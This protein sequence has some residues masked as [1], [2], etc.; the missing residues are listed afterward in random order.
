MTAED[1]LRWMAHE[2]AEARGRD[3]CEAVCLT[4]VWLLRVLN[5]PPMDDCEARAF[6]AGLCAELA[7]VEANDFRFDPQPSRVGCEA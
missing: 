3:A 5:L 6:K 4:H 7:A 1:A 2:A